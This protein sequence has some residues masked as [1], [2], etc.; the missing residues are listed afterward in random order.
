MTNKYTASEIKPL[1]L[2]FA[3]RALLPHDFIGLTGADQR[4]SIRDGQIVKFDYIGT[5][6]NSDGKYDKELSLI[7]IGLYNVDIDRLSEIWEQRISTKSTIWHEVR[8]VRV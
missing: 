5:W 1:D 2:K 8:M 7:S 6:D 4:Y 3:K